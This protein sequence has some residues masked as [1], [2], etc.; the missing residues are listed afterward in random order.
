MVIDKAYV[1]AKIAFL[2]PVI[3][4]FYIIY[5]GF[6]LSK[7][8]IATKSIPDSTEKELLRINIFGNSQQE[9]EN[10]VSASFSLIDSSGNEIAVIERS[11]VGNYLTIDF[12][13]VSINKKIFY[14]PSEICSK[15]Q[16]YEGSRLKH[17]KGTEL[18]RYY[19]EN[20]QCMLLGFASTK[21][22]R[23][24]L[25]DISSFANGHFKVPRF[26]S[27]KKIGIDL[28]FCR[29]GVYYSVRAEKD[30]NLKLAPL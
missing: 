23:H 18:S 5:W 12:Y 3:I 4:V 2:I 15:D 10:T 16:I 28:S 30:G 27:V 22:Q 20:G 26:F 9:G 8:Y 29:T 17:K 21:K 6:T 7:V 13:R 24:K 25:Y 19:D 1:K 14:F 11:W